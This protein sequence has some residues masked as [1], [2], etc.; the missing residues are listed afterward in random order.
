MTKNV[1][2]FSLSPLVQRLQSSVERLFPDD[3]SDYLT[4]KKLFQLL[5]LTLNNELCRRMEWVEYTEKSLRDGIADIMAQMPWH[6]YP[7][8]RELLDQVVEH[9][10]DPAVVAIYELL[11]DLVEVPE[12][13]MDVYLLIPHAG[14]DYEYLLTNKG[15][16][17][18]YVW[19]ILKQEANN[20]DCWDWTPDKG[21]GGFGIAEEWF[22]PM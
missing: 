5:Y 20:S 15:D 18:I 21:I 22:P 10:Y 9:I 12:K 19:N 1:V 4:E 16:Y 8:Q 14:G 6:K 2:L 7:H 3:M 17:R 11:D 13:T